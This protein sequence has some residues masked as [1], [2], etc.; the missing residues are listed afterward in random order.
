VRLVPATHEVGVVEEERNAQ[1]TSAAAPVQRLVSRG[2]GALQW[3]SGHLDAH[4]VRVYYLEPRT[5]TAPLWG[6]RLP[7]LR[8]ATPLQTERGVVTAVYDRRL[9]SNLVSCIDG[10]EAV[11]NAS[12]C[13]AEHHRGPPVSADRYAWAYT[14][15]RGLPRAGRCPGRLIGLA[16]FLGRGHATA[17]IDVAGTLARIHRRCRP[18][19]GRTIAIVRTGIQIRGG[20]GTIRGRGCATAATCASLPRTVTPRCRAVDRQRAA[21]VRRPEVRAS[22]RG[23]QGHHRTNQK[24]SQTS[25]GNASSE[26]GP[27]PAGRCYTHVP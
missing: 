25:H 24:R 4:L 9:S 23:Q 20:H 6:F 7:P 1:S 18:E 14:H 13:P 12:A 26:T 27:A 2:Q 22:T 17:A 3:R 15:L 16:P 19:A 11:E 8:L 5:T 21:H 10:K